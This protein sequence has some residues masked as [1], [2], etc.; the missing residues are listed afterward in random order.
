MDIFYLW[1]KPFV[2]LIDVATRYKIAYETPSRE[3]GELLK[4]LLHRW[5]SIFGPMRVLTS[6]QESAIMSSTAAIEFERLGVTR[7]PK[8]TTAGEA[9]RQHTGTGLVERHVAL[10]KLTMQKGW[11]IL[12]WPPNQA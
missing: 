6:D 5:T 1:P 8:G 7:N 12:M 9:G 2:L 11:R 10:I 4:G 3:T